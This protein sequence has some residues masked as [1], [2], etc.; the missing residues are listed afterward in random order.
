MENL[1]LVLYFDVHRIEIDSGA[2]LECQTNEKFHMMMLVEGE[3]INVRTM[4][5]YEKSFFM[6]RLFLYMPRQILLQLRI[7][8]KNVPR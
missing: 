1:D 5:G 4:N 7:N 8:Q 2:R 3:R 6:P